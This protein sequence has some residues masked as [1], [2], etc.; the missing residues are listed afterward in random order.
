MKCVKKN[1]AQIVLIILLL[2]ITSFISIINPILYKHTID[3]II[4]LADISY[5]ILFLFLMTFVPWVS[6]VLSSIKNY[7]ITKLGEKFTRALRIECLEKKLVF[8]I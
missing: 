8:E 6:V 4:P 3:Y 1:I 7:H 2:I 5:L